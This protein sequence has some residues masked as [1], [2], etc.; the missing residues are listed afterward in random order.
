M[1]RLKTFAAAGLAAVGLA[2]AAAAQQPRAETP[3]QQAIRQYVLPAIVPPQPAP[4][5]VPQPGYL[6]RPTTA[7]PYRTA[8]AYS[9]YRTDPGYPYQSPVYTVP[10]A[11]A[12]VVVPA[13]AATTDMA[14][15]VT[16]LSAGPAAAAGL[17]VGDVILS[18][19]GDRV[20]SFDE[21]AAKVRRGG[22]LHIESFNP[23]LGRTEA[24]RVTPVDGRIG[25]V[26][27]EVPVTVRTGS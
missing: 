14:L 8:P 21:L 26:V 19:N 18:V 11:P 15:K 12:P 16:E 5:M 1:T 7:D 3:V 24:R 4:S 27:D 10:A 2:G 20:R 17:A 25:V 22:P 6:V 9:P 23:R 13:P